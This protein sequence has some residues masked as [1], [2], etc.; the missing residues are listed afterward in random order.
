MPQ[1]GIP[2][3]DPAAQGT[4][5]RAIGEISSL[6][7]L[8]LSA[9]KLAAKSSFV[10]PLS[11]FPQVAQWDIR[12]DPAKASSFRCMEELSGDTNRILP[13]SQR[14][15]MQ[16]SKSSGASEAIQLCN[17]R[18]RRNVMRFFDIQ[19]KSVLLLTRLN[20]SRCV[21]L[22]RVSEGGFIAG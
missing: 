17:D 8:D 1:F 4:P 21:V 10:R 18:G 3:G 11:P 16:R 6:E 14:V 2:F 9:K 20:S 15:R 19:K 13:K 12:I 5:L 7:Q 22:K